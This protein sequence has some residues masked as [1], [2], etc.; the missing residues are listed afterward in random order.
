MKIHCLGVNSALE[1]SSFDTNLLIE[2][3]SDIKKDFDKRFIAFDVG[4]TWPEAMNNAGFSWMSVTDV[5]ITH[6][7]ADHTGG[8]EWLAFNNYFKRGF[9]F[10]LHRLE[11]YA[12]KNVMS[13]L[14]SNCLRAGLESVQGSVNNIH[15]Y[16]DVS[17]IPLNGQFKINNHLFKIVQTV[18]VIDNM[19]IKPSSGLIIETPK[20]TKIFLTGDTQFC[21]E[22]IRTYYEQVDYIIQDCELA[23]YPNSVHAQFYQLKTLDENVRKKMYLIH[24]Y[25]S[26]PPEEEAKKFGF[27]GFLKTGQIL[28]FD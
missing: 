21:P 20:G 18:H 3:D 17:S 1:H 11:L 15:S 19:R 16:F 24:Y 6:L 27:L 10:G 9:P 2:L 5:F 28:E 4:R 12:D 26:T 23:C 14:W 7:H 22:Q 8:L 13:E 25:G